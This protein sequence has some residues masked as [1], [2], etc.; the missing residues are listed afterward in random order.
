[1]KARGDN[2]NQPRRTEENEE[3]KKSLFSSVLLGFIGRG[4]RHVAG[5]RPETMKMWGRFS[6]LP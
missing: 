6:N 5:G 4:V 3:K 1:V 2:E